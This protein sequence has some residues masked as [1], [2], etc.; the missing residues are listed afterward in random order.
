MGGIQFRCK[1]NENDEIFKEKRHITTFYDQVS[2]L[3][4]DENVRSCEDQVTYV[5]TVQVNITK[6]SPS[7]HHPKPTKSPSNPKKLTNYDS[8]ITRARHLLYPCINSS[9]L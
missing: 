7:L 9:Y 6:A 2:L 5:V 3:H 8:N 4:V 1:T